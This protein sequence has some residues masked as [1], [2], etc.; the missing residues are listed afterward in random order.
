MP[1]V[2]LDLT[3]FLYWIEYVKLDI[4]SMVWNLIK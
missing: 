3:A 2:K 4:D 1:L